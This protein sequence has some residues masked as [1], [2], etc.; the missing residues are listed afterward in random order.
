MASSTVDP[1][2]F[3]VIRH[4]LWNINIEH[5]ELL[6]RASGS[7]I[8]AHG[9]DL[10]PCILTAEGEYVFVGPYVQ[11]LASA[12]DMAVRWLLEHEDVV[13]GI[14][15]GDMFLTN[16]PWIGATHQLDVTLL[17]PVF[18]GDQLFC[19]VANSLHEVDLGGPT[20]GGMGSDVRDIFSEP[21]PIPPIKLVFEGELRRDLEAMYLRRSRLPELVGLDLH[22]GLSGNGTARN[23]IVALVERYGIETV[24][25][26]MQGIIDNSERAFLDRIGRLSKGT[27][28]ERGWL[29]QAFPGD[30]NVYPVQVNVTNGGDGLTFSNAGTHAQVGGLNSTFAGWRAALVN[31]VSVIFCYDMMCAIGGP[32]RR[33]GFDYESGTICTAEYPAAVANSTNFAIMLNVGLAANAISR[34]LISDPGQRDRM[35]T[36]AGSSTAPVSMLSGVNQHGDPWA[37]LHMEIPAG[38]IGAF[39]TKDGIPTGGVL[40]SYGTR[41]PDAETEEQD[42]PILFLY[43]RQCVD[44]GG[45]GRWAR[46][47]GPVAAQVAHGTDSIR[48]DLAACGVAVPTGP[49]L[50]GGYPGC[51]SRVRQVLGSDLASWF[52]RGEIPSSI[53]QLAGEARELQPKSSGLIQRPGDVH[54]YRLCAGAGYGDPLLR[55]ATLVAEDV[56]L[57]YVS[58]EAAARL[59]GVVLHAGVPDLDATTA[60]RTE[61]RQRRLGGASLRP[62]DP[63]EGPRISEYLILD[64]DESI[65]CRM[66]G[67]DMGPRNANYKERAATFVTSLQ[68][69][70]AL[71]VDPQMYIDA[72]MEYRQFSC[73]AC[74]TLL[75][76]EIARSDAPVLRDIE[77]R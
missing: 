37:G 30:R 7:L 11:I 19:W 66:C 23:A 26:V 31:A 9:R 70:G 6:A 36:P 28:R 34:M 1:I 42:R 17:C 58:T 21:C 65:A 68:D 5:G 41:M 27:W 13:G 76:T 33:I 40:W 46:G 52:Q 35:V 57:G 67:E 74:G 49:G 25:S 44:S 29:E 10:N 72:P 60:L 73:P 12:A 24:R 32:L 56:R 63:R 45:A 16:D 4:N 20:P 61:I 55:E 8:V 2:T 77:L 43:R 54:E 15:P 71:I 59:Y 47:V 75:E 38:G 48:H 64:G 3:E 53:E 62:M 50:F 18:V 51:T 39:A 14:H 22:A 69:A